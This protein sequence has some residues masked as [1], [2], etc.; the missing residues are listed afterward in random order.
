MVVFCSDHGD[1]MGDHW[2][3]EKDLFYD[4]S[5]RV[6]MLVYDPRPEADATRGTVVNDL[7]EAIDLVPTFLDFSMPNQS[8]MF[9]RGYRCNQSCMGRKRIGGNLQCR[10]MTMPP[11]MH[12][13]R[14]GLSNAM[15]GL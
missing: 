5:A 4:C 12:G 9:W 13:D 7:V 10:N 14:R 2:M 6:P 11:A 3:G 15:Q 1:N 8:R